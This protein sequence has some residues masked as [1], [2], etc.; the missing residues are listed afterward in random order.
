[1]TNYSTIKIKQMLNIAVKV[2]NKMCCS[3]DHLMILII[4]FI[5]F[6]CSVKKKERKRIIMIKIKNPL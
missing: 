3:I 2:I 1:M 6:T 4:C 5:I